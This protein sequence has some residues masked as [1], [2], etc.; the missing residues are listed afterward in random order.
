M[1]K[2]ELNISKYLLCTYGV[3]NNITR[4]SI[5]STKYLNYVL[6]NLGA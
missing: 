1:F 3:E 6:L 5:L 4:F 2:L